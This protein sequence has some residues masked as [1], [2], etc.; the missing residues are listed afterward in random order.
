MYMRSQR[1]GLRIKS[2]DATEGRLLP[3][4]IVYAIPLIISTLLQTL[5]NAVDIVVLRYAA[6]NEIGRAHV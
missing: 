3:L 4:I 2:I 6:D 5:F 1:I